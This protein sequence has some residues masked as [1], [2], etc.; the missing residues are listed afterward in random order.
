MRPKEFDL[1]V[2]TD[3]AMQVFWLKGYSGTSIQDLVDGTGLSRSSLYGTFENKHTLYQKTLDR[4][5]AVTTANIHCLEQEQ[6]AKA[7]IKRLLMKIAEDEL[8]D[9]LQRGC[10]IA[11]ASLELAGQDAL[12]AE[13]VTQNLQRLQK[14]IVNVLLK[15]QHQGEISKEID[16]EALSFFIVNTIQGMR[17]LAKG[18]PA[19]ERRQCLLNIIDIA[20]RV[21]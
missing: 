8:A 18:T 7:A 20:L 10:L 9:P 4:Y 13:K 15:A 19:H 6:S 14:A 5:D 12:I 3:A 16:A 17:V 1:D 2:V 11:N 21:F